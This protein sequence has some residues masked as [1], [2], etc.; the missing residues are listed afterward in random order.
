MTLTG[1]TPTTTPRT[2]G[3]EVT[4]PALI[5]D[6]GRTM[7]VGGEG[8]LDPGNGHG[9]GRSVD[10]ALHWLLRGPLPAPTDRWPGDD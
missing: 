4:G 1:A 3:L 2:Q 6:H 9:R 7:L 5:R 8:R 10:L